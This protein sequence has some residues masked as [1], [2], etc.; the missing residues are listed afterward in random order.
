LS[1]VHERG[2]NE[3]RNELELERRKTLSNLSQNIATKKCEER[4]QKRTKR[5]RAHTK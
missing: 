1:D 3:D 4:L 5:F 2:K